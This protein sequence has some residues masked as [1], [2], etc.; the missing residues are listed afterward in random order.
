MFALTLPLR[1]QS[2]SAEP[3]AARPRA[4]RPGRPLIRHDLLARLWEHDAATALHSLRVCRHAV[5]LAEA[6]DLD[7]RQL[8]A[9]PIAACL[10]DIGKM[11]VPA[12]ILQKPGAL[13]AREHRWILAHPAAGERLLAGHV[14]ATV[15]AAV[16]GHHERFDG[17]G[18]PDGLAGEQIP[19][20]ARILALADSFDA[21]ISSRPYRPGMPAAAALERLRQAAGTQFDPELVE[22]FVAEVER[23]GADLTLQRL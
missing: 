14:S 15:L 19:L 5:R 2:D 11:A 12:A 21:M 16:R 17:T 6:L 20:L 1:I 9:L 7:A 10:H 13:T 3:L 8:A 4:T 18:Y 23:G 22:L